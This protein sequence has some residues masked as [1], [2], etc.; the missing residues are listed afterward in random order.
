MY[1]RDT[2]LIATVQKFF[3][4]FPDPYCFFGSIKIAV[5]SLSGITILCSVWVR[6]LLRF[7]NNFLWIHSTPCTLCLRKNF[8]L[9]LKENYTT[10]NL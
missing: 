1:L 8:S 4:N 9:Y 3:K 2:K 7:Q 6:P 5:I 10:M